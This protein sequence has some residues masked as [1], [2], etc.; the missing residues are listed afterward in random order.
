MTKMTKQ[1]VRDLDSL[2]AKPAG[3]RLPEPPKHVGLCHHPR[4]AELELESGFIKCTAC[5]AITYDPY[6]YLY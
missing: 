3:I 4:S 2:P 6:S 1:G 5:G